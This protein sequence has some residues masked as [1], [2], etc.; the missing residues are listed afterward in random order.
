MAEISVRT[1]NIRPSKT[2]EVS[3]TGG[4]S[5][6]M[7]AIYSY[8][9]GEVLSDQSRLHQ[10]VD[11][12]WFYTS[13]L[14]I[15]TEMLVVKDA[16]DADFPTSPTLSD[17]NTIDMNTSGPLRLVCDIIAN[18]LGL[19]TDQVMIYNQQFNIPSDNRLYITVG[20]LTSKPYAISRAKDPD[21]PLSMAQEVSIDIN[22]FGPTDTVIESK[23]QLPLVFQ[24]TYSKNQQSFNEFFIADLPTVIN[25]LN[26]L[27]GPSQQYRY[28]LQ[29]RMY[30]T[31]VST[32]SIDYFDSFSYDNI[33]REG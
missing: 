33:I 6:Y 21:V 9:A 15:G 14:D 23:D 28:L 10:A 7:F 32:L 18:G 17:E 1:N 31:T 16:N 3:G 19:A 27:E 5:P 30:Y 2:I 20:I 29:Y 11:G 12:R 8:P 22:I 4:V 26:Y 24:G 25:N 13:P